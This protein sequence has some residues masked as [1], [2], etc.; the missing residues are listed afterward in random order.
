MKRPLFKYISVHLKPEE[1]IGLHAHEEWEL[2]YVVS[3]SGMR[4]IGDHSEPF[5]SGELFLIPP[6]V[7]HCWA[8]D[9]NETDNMGNIATIT[10]CFST[11]L[12]K[13]IASFPEWTEP[14]NSLLGLAS[15]VRL[16]ERTAWKAYTP[17]NQMNQMSEADRLWSFIRVMV[18][19]AN[20]LQGKPVPQYRN[21]SKEQ[22]QKEEIQTYILCNSHKHLRLD[23]LAKHVGMSRSTFC[24]FFKKQFGKTFV[25]HL[26]E[27]RLSNACR[28]LQEGKYS[29]SEV[30]YKVGFND[31]PYFTRI[32][33]RAMGMTPAEFSRNITKQK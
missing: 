33:K 9:K 22:K 27:C 4:Q 20:D 19:V 30:C 1:Q 7:P 2:S 31:I 24:L 5:R 21:R 8:F 6:N 23:S 18:V 12:L 10:L 3:G 26:N 16:P 14:M 17:L 32:F 15:A 28:L 11:E 13:K 25:A 29:V